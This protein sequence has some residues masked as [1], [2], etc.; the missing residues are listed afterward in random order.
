MNELSRFLFMRI[1]DQ[2]PKLHA[3]GE[4]INSDEIKIEEL[5]TGGE[6]TLIY[7]WSVSCDICKK[8]LLICT[9]NTG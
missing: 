5:L 2:L 7:F 6:S 8:A 9:S 3:S 1:N 4:W